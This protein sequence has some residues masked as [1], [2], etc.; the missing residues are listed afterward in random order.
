MI[1]LEQFTSVH[2][3]S[4]LCFSHLRWNFVYQRPQ[5]LL[6]R[7]QKV[8]DVHFWEEP[9]YKPLNSP[10]LQIE[11]DDCGLRIL[12]PLLPE[13]IDNAL[14]INLQRKLL[15]QYLEQ[16]KIK[17]HISWYYTPMALAFSSHLTPRVTVYD[18]M[19]ELSAFDG[20]PPE[21]I[22]MEEQLFAKA[23]VV[24]TGG[25]SLH[26]T[27]RRQH[28]NV[29]LF[30]SSIDRDH[31]SK[32][33]LPLPDPSDQASIPHPRVGFYGVLDERL[34]QA[35]LDAVAKRNPS[36]HLVLVGPVAKIDPGQLPK[37]ANIHYLGQKN[38]KELPNYLANWDVA[39]LPFAQNASTRFISPTKTPE[40]LAAGKPVVS[41]PI[42]DVVRPYGELGLVDIGGDADS[43]EA[44]IAAC[45]S[46][47]DEKWLARVDEFI[48][49][50]SWDRTFDRMWKE[51][52]RCIR[53][54]NPTGTIDVSSTHG[55]SYV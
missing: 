2:P 6:C 10:E 11:T 30:P 1:V 27:K 29:H 20:A 17:H 48:G 15:N 7:C 33:R 35:L 55:E 53:E 36:W 18:C 12:R 26:E 24:F 22:G 19:D 50:M 37:G 41:T 43:F 49:E 46:R 39:M 25:A 54:K 4:V 9:L 14:A 44:G 52:G 51:I 32:A 5:H 34:D 8:C 21:L 31:F 42:R 13:G 3:C 23:D 38:Y 28:R 47:R 45:L 40:Y 16:E